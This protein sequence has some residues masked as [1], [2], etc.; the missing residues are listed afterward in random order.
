MPKKKEE[1]K[2]EEGCFKS[3]TLF[4]LLVLGGLFLVVFAGYRC[5]RPMVLENTAHFE[6]SAFNFSPPDGFVS[7]RAPLLPRD[8]GIKLALFSGREDRE[9]SLNSFSSAISAGGWRRQETGE[10]I[11]EAK[12]SASFGLSL[13]KRKGNSLFFTRGDNFLHIN[14]FRFWGRSYAFIVSGKKK[15]LAAD[16]DLF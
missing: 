6:E 2:K 9:E 7:R 4:L 10:V 15:L 13:L 1:N 8:S 14:V 12:K 11:K 16:E 3:F 5:I